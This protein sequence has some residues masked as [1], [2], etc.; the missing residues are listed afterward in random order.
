VRTPAVLVGRALR[1]A[2]LR[3]QRLRPPR[4]IHPRGLPLSGD[5]FWGNRDRVAGIAWIDEPPTGA[6][7]RVTARYSRSLGLPDAFPDVLGLALRVETD[8]G[9]ADIE[10]ASTGS[11]VPWRFALVPRWIPSRGVFTTLIPYRGGAG[12]IL[13]RA[14]PLRPSLPAGVPAISKILTDETW[15]LSLAFAT[16]GGSWHPFALLSLDSRRGD[17]DVRF[18]AG[19]NVL[20]G[21]R[22]YRWVSAVRQPSYDAVQ[23]RNR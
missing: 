9:H 7:A 12:A 4:P 1:H 11:G 18:D 8:D 21:A 17:P 13:L 6:R 2:F 3:L 23:R 15:R 20:P 22:M 16:P 19:R 10:L 14:R 5:V